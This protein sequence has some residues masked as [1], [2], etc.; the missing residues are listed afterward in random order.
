[1]TDPTGGPAT[2]PA[3]DGPTVLVADRPPTQPAGRPRRGKA[4]RAPGEK[5]L[6]AGVF[7]FPAGILLAA[8]MLYPLVYSIVRSLFGDGP[9]GAM[10][11]FIGLH[12]YVTVFTDSSTLRAVKNNLIWLVVA[13]T[14]VTILGLIFA[15]LSERIRWV[16]VF[17]TVLFIPMAIS[18]LAVGVTFALIYSDQPSRGLANAVTVGVHDIFTTST[19]YPN[20]HPL[21]ATKFSGSAKSG[22]TSKTSYSAATPATL[23]L[24]GLDLTSPPAGLSSAKLPVAGS[25]L[26]GVVWNDFKLGGGGTS[27]KVDPGELGLSGLTVEAVRNGT[28]AATATT[29]AKGDFA[30]PALKSGSYHLRMPAQDFSQPFSGLSWLG[31]NLITPA[32]IVAYLWVYAGFAMVLLAAGMA[33]IPR[34]ALEAARIDGAT[35]WQVF[36]RITAPL[37]AP[38]LTVVFVTLVINVLK[39]FDLVF[40]ISQSAG[41]NGVY[42]NVLA[43]ELFNDYGNQQFGL[44]SAIGVVL[45]IVLLPAMAFNIRRFRRGQ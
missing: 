30:F 2:E 16:T 24:V 40:I 33:A 17:K 29:D 32:I 45:V 9:A 39:I 12:N 13:P 18:G 20:E 35:E 15:V 41:A 3:V 6:L 27:G 22:Y 38:V 10:G 19:G 4:P 5:G 25:G 42:A 11:S 43:V 8:I 34:D 7:L 23:P 21:D 44:A 37:L 36:R 31:P 14:I 1:M 28:V 26:T